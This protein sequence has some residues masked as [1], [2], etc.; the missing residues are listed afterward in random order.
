MDCHVLNLRRPLGKT[1]DSVLGCFP[2]A[3]TSISNSQRGKPIQRDRL[4]FVG[5]DPLLPHRYQPV[6][7]DA[8]S[9]VRLRVLVCRRGKL[10]QLDKSFHLRQPIFGDGDL[11]G[12][13]SHPRR[14]GQSAEWFRHSEVY[15]ALMS[16]TRWIFNAEMGSRIP[17]LPRRQRVMCSCGETFYAP[18]E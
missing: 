5:T 14:G 18:I 12:G 17:D 16:G 6:C 11:E 8:I 13:R 9:T 3:F 10:R 4:P 7:R 15:R 2:I 1:I